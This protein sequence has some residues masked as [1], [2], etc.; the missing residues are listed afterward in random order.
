MKDLLLKYAKYN[1]WAND[2]LVNA[3]KTNAPELIEK[4]IASSF[5]SI[6]KTVLHMADAEYIWHL[7][8]TGRTPD[9]MPSKSP[10]ASIDTLSL[11]NRMLIDFIG[12]QD[13]TF[14]HQSSSYRSLKGDPYTTNNAA[15]LWHVF[16]HGTFHR[17]QIVTMLRNGGYNG[18]LEQ[19]D[20]IAFERI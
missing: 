6:L 13:E 1:A 12:A 16:N 10:Y 11:T 15:I 2:K 4:E 20:L 8:L 9:V 5:N 19:T 17:G 18:S 14:F 3:I 7:R